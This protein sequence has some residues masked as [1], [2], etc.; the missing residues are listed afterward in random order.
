MR[1]MGQASR[2]G[3]YEERVAQAQQ[4]ERLKRAA[5]IRVQLER[6]QQERL[7]WETMVWWQR[8]MTMQRIKGFLAR[9][10][11]IQGSLSQLLTYFGMSLAGAIGPDRSR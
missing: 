8:E 4:R 3:T 7:A 6:A 10:N 9:Q 2:H 11:R 5:E 1:T